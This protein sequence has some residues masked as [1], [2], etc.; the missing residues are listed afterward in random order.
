MT[1]PRRPSLLQARDLHPHAHSRRLRHVHGH[2]RD[3]QQQN[4]HQYPHDNQQVSEPRD[5]PRDSSTGN[6]PSIHDRFIP[7]VDLAVDAV[8]NNPLVTQVI[9]TVSLVQVVD[10]AKS[11]ASSLTI[12]DLPSVIVDTSASETSTILPPSNTSTTVAAPGATTSSEPSSEIPSFSTNASTQTTTISSTL[13]SF[14]S[15]SSSSPLSSSSQATITPSIPLSKFPTFVSDG[16][17]ATSTFSS[18]HH[19]N[20]TTTTTTTSQFYAATKNATFTVTSHSASKTFTLTSTTTT[21]SASL[22][23]STWLSDSVHSTFVSD[24]AATG[25]VVG[26]GGADSG[27]GSGAAGDAS[28]PTAKQVIGGVVG[29]VAGAAFFALFIMLLLRYKRRRDNRDILSITQAAASR[30]LPSSD[31]GG[32]G[33]G[34]G[35]GTGGAMMERYSPAAISAALTGLASKRNVTPTSSADGGERGFYRVSGRKLPSVLQVGGDGYTDPRESIISTN[36]DYYRGSQ[37]FE[38]ADGLTTRLALG[39][40]MRPVSGVPIIRSGP[41]RTPVTERNPFSDPPSTPPHDGQTQLLVPRQSPEGSRF[42]E[43]I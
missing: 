23:T 37:A 43:S 41:A 8:A 24:P 20:A 11:L 22:S 14:S 42:Q 5:S 13:S 30:G 15:S 3:R 17:N 28:Q 18:H 31:R 12:P 29:G 33:T 34:D 36:S 35:S 26:G 21:N 38:P 25:V 32:P 10:T 27:S 39:N 19:T 6:V 4:Q 9:Q 16:R 2:D 7:A 40:P 1:N